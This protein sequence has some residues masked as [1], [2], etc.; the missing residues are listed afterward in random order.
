[1]CKVSYDVLR[2][3]LIKN[4]PTTIIT[5]HFGEKENIRL[6]RGKGCKICHSTGYTGRLGLFE[7]LEVTKDI[8]ALITAKNDSD[9]ITKKAIEEGMTTMLN[10][11]LNKVARGVT[12]LEEVLRVT[13][14]ESL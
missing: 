8:K 4:L 3:D 11:G 13:K 6:Y 5:R 2:T 10:D 9:V 12:T 7:V 1:M 14:V